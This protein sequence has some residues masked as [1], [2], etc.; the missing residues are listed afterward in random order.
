MLVLLVMV[1]KYVFLLYCLLMQVL[2]VL[3]KQH[4]VVLLLLHHL[5]IMNQQVEMMISGLLVMRVKYSLN[6]T[7]RIMNIILLELHM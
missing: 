5:Q 4:M 7:T 1:H 6:R 2:F 3:L